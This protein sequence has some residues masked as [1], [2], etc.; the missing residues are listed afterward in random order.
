MTRKSYITPSLNFGPKHNIRR[1][2]KRK[3]LFIWGAFT[4]KKKSQACWILKKDTSFRLY[5]H[6]SFVKYS[7]FH[8]CTTHDNIRENSDQTEGEIK[9]L[10]QHLIRER[11]KKPVFIIDTRH[12]WCILLQGARLL[13]RLESY[14]SLL[15]QIIMITWHHSGHLKESFFF[16]PRMSKSKLAGR[17]GKPPATTW[18]MKTDE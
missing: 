7:F 3:R 12:T 8:L 16:S 4:K 2:N 11:I 17:C 18:C 6:K 9:V 14:Q 10:K 5:L 15:S 1:K 13:S